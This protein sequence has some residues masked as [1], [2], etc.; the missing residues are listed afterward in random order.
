M[1]TSPLS[2]I[3]A[4]TPEF[5]CPSLQALL[6]SPHTVIAVYT[7]PDRPAGR[8]RKLT[9]SPVKQLA[10]AHGIPVFQPKT[11]KDP[12]EQ[13]QLREL[14]PDLM[15]V[16]AYGLILPA[17][18]L[19]IPRFGCINVH[20]SLLP[21]W[22]GAAP[23]QYA[24]RAGDTKTGIT[25]MQMDKGMDTGDSLLMLDCP[26]TETDTA[27]LLTTRLADLGAEA[28]QLGLKALVEGTLSATPQDDSLA[29]YAPKI[30][31]A[32]AAVDWTQSATALSRH[33]RAY[34]PWPVASATHEDVI[35]RLHQAVPVDMAST[36][37]PGTIIAVDKQGIDVACG[38]GV[39]R[40]LHV[41]RPGGKPLPVSDLLNQSTQPLTLGSCFS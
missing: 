2:L 16:A 34:H 5:S 10:E 19:S 11:L 40:L 24:L 28:V 31:K 29:S 25:L 12:A 35:Y 18:V 4:G 20:A 38:E 37:K 9:A 1:T 27:G 26:I 41:Q 17:S 6:D 15:V 7:Q 8:G 36:E 3:F 39:L 23:I 33:I 30:K 32:D 21:H 14:A 13:T 22:R